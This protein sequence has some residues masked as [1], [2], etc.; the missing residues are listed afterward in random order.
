MLITLDLIDGAARTVCGAVVNGILQSA[1]LLLATL[2]PMYLLRTRLNAAMHYLIWYVFLVA[3]GI[4][5]ILFVAAA[6][7]DQQTGGKN[8]EIVLGS[9]VR[10]QM[11]VSSPA[12]SPNISEKGI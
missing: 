6:L 12:V 1:V 5:P 10:K 2:L 9:D 4:L 11:D 8:I 7:Y 3:I